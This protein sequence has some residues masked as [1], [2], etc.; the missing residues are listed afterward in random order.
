MAAPIK[1]LKDGI[2]NNDW[3]LVCQAYE[4]LTGETIDIPN[5]STEQLN[6]EDIL[7]IVLKRLKNTDQ[8]PIK[9]SIKKQSKKTSTKSKFKKKELIESLKDDPDE[10]DIETVDYIPKM[11]SGPVKGSKKI[12]LPTVH[13][14]DEEEI[15]LNKSMLRKKEY[16]DPPKKIMKNCTEC[17]S[18]FDFN[19]AYPMGKIDRRSDIYLCENCQNNSRK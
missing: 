17:K 15:K 4:A 5:T 11:V 6:T 13:L 10:D 12:V 18:K 8:K 7:E 16:R 2:L 1:I 3:S 19:K 14:V 9:K